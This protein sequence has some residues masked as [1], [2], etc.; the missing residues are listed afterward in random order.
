MLSTR[1]KAQR[2][3]RK[4]A[5]SFASSSAKADSPG[6]KIPRLQAALS[7]FSAQHIRHRRIDPHTEGEATHTLRRE[8][9]SSEVNQC[10]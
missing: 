3:P 8:S 7:R 2:V 1:R 6:G 9:D 5:F 10:N 4:T